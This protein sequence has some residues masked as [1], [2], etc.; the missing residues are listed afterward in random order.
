MRLPVFYNPAMEAEPATLTDTAGMISAPDNPKGKWWLPGKENQRLEG[1]LSHTGVNNVKLVVDQPGFLAETRPDFVLGELADGRPVTVYRGWA[2]DSDHDHVVYDAEAAFLGIH[3]TSEGDLRFHVLSVSYPRLDAWLAVTFINS[4]QTAPFVAGGFDGG[5]VEASPAKPATPMETCSAVWFM[6]MRSRVPLPYSELRH[7]LLRRVTA[8]MTLARFDAV[9]PSELR[10]AAA[11]TDGLGDIIVLTHGMSA[12]S[13]E[14]A[15]LLMYDNADGMIGSYLDRWL[16]NGDRFDEVYD[17]YVSA[18]RDRPSPIRAQF[19]TLMQA[20][21]GYLRVAQGDIANYLGPDVQLALKTRMLTAAKETDLN[22][23]TSFTRDVLPLRL[24]RI[25]EW[26][27]SKRLRHHGTLLQRALKKPDGDEFRPLSELHVPCQRLVEV[28]NLL[29]HVDKPREAT[30]VAGWEEPW[31]L[32]R[33]AKLVLEAS[34]LRDI[35][36]TDDKVADAIYMQYQCHGTIQQ[37]W[38]NIEAARHRL[39]LQ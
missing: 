26:S 25:A 7:T 23:P 32:S 38:D 33:F 13:P 28:R 20:L 11:D 22:L 14:P 17:L 16:A 18:V 10:V 24:E 37:W 8:F 36:M 27:L 12:R 31:V 39:P 29:I 30:Q 3:A 15:P 9:T 5:F 4:D 21:E 35:G 34:L 6:R 19:L 1:T 2:S